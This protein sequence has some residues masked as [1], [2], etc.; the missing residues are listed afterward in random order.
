VQQRLAST[1]RQPKLCQFDYILYHHHII[2]FHKVK[3]WIKYKHV[4][5]YI[6]YL[7]AAR[8][9][10]A[11]HTL[12]LERCLECVI[13]AEEFAVLSYLFQSRQINVRYLIYKAINA[14]SMPCPVLQLISQVSLTPSFLDSAAIV[15][16]ELL[17]SISLLLMIKMVSGVIDSVNNA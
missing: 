7:P 8:S 14:V 10:A 6:E 12:R 16:V 11:R 3:T 13:R 15:F 4:I 5:Y 17:L 1:L 9:K 2:R